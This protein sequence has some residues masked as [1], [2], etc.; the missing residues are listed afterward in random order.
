MESPDTRQSDTIDTREIPQGS[1]DFLTAIHIA[2]GVTV[3]KPPANPH[4]AVT[5]FLDDAIARS[6]RID[7][8]V[9]SFEHGALIAAA[10]GVESPG[11]AALVLAPT[12]TTDAATIARF[13]PVVKT[14]CDGLRRR[15]VSLTELLAPSG[16]NP[17]NAVAKD[18][19]LDFL[20]D[21]I[22]LVRG[23]GY[24]IGPGNVRRDVD[25]TPLT[26]DA[27]SLFEEALI[28]TYEDS[29]DCP[30]LCG[31]R[32]AEEVLAGHQAAGGFDGA[33][34]SVASYEGRPVGILLLARLPRYNALEL[35]YMGIS[36][37]ARNNGFADALLRRAVDTMQLEGAT[38]L[39]LA[40]D[41]R[42]AQ[43]RRVYERWGFTE[44]GR[45][46]AWVTSPAITIA[47]ET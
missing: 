37:N 39:A 2:L 44:T 24:E 8:V 31:M 29:A 15:S 26:R 42:N 35:V 20:T 7:P 19:G 34:W 43:A 30:E 27:R 1:A 3:R 32:T 17:W 28:S 6:L 25:W 10:V 33:L 38:K 16:E 40:V 5:E 23:C 18:A 13:G 4:A 46:S 11:S 41:I 36:K 9:G 21:L 12:E 14:V 47:C 22:Y 45:R